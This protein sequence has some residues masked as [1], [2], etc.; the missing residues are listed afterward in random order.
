MTPHTIARCRLPLQA[1]SA[2][3]QV[4]D[5]HRRLD[6]RHHGRLDDGVHRRVE[7]GLGLQRRAE[8]GDAL[9]KYFVKLMLGHEWYIFESDALAPRA[10]TAPRGWPAGHLPHA[11]PK[12]LVSDGPVG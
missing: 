12:S 4:L 1:K 10:A 5:R 2:S 6:G 3:R 11:F 7:V 9:R 8:N